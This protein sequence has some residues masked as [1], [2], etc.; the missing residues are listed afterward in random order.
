[1]VDYQP[2]ASVAVADGVGVVTQPTQQEVDRVT[3]EEP[4][5]NTRPVLWV[6]A[7]L[8]TY[9]GLQ[10]LNAITAFDLLQEGYG[11]SLGVASAM[12]FLGGSIQ[13]AP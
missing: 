8:S 3:K 5:D 10:L 13:T 7:L 11:E 6:N 2:L 1:M 9:A 12:P 4:S